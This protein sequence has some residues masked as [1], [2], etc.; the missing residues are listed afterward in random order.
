MIVTA[1]LAVTAHNVCDLFP[2]GRSEAIFKTPGHRTQ[3]GF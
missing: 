2:P 3:A 1:T